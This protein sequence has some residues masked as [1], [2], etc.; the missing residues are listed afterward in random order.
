MI[1]MGLLLQ[2]KEKVE[3]NIR[4]VKKRGVAGLQWTESSL[5]ST[6]KGGSGPTE[7]G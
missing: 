5:P 7:R 6:N 4:I 2:M 3:K 1:R